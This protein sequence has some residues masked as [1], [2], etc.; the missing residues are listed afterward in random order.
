MKAVMK[1][2][3]IFPLGVIKES[4]GI[5]VAACL[6]PEKECGIVLFRKG[7]DVKE[8]CRVPFA[9]HMGAV[10]YGK[11][12]G[13]NADQV[14]YCF[15]EDDRLVSDPYMRKAAGKHRY[16]EMPEEFCL[17]RIYEDDYNWEDDQNPC[18]PWNDAICYQLHV[19]GFTKH[20][21]SKVVHKGTFAGVIEKIPYLQQLGVTT[22]EFLP[23]YDFEE[24]QPEENVVGVGA[25]G[26]MEDL[27]L[28]EEQQP[29]INYWGFKEGFYLLPKTSYSSN[30]DSCQEMKDLVKRL[31]QAGMEIILQFFFPKDYRMEQIKEVLTW[32]KQEYHVDGF[33]VK[34]ENIQIEQLATDP[35]FQDTKLIYEGFDTARIYPGKQL[36]VYKNLAYY[37]E[38]YLYELRRFLKGDDNMIRN[39]Q[40][41]FY[42]S[43]PY[44]G[45]LHSLSNYNTFTMLDMVS[46][47]RKHNEDNGEKN[48]D[49]SDNNCSWNCGEEG[50]SRKRT[51]VALRQ[52]Q[53][54]NAFL[55]LF[56]MQG[57]P[58][59][60]AGDEFG[61]TQ[62]G[63]NNP[64]CQDNS[65]NWINWKYK[66]KN[67]ELL[68]FVKTLISFRKE[69][70]IFHREEGLHMM[71]TL[72]CGCPD[73]SF[74]SEEAWRN[75]QLPYEH[76]FGAML[77]G[78]YAQ[79]ADGEWDDSFY[80]AINM[81]WQKHVFALPNLPKGMEWV[82]CMETGEDKALVAD[83]SRKAVLESR[84]I[85]I[86]KSRPIKG[87]KSDSCGKAG[88]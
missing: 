70:P 51:I 81:H 28:G 82:L 6:K 61:R 45:I 16:G 87:K 64:W 50:A 59:I 19:R 14:T 53:L 30:P 33:H 55:L 77:C 15:Y 26:S 11:L 84:S 4:D 47:D 60:M 34:G 43:S 22:L 5:H 27:V 49:G 23:V 24:V 71:D 80:L 75:R 73:L 68:Q 36:P 76:H 21:S 88:R 10:Y 52:K 9:C 2:D 46:Y 29:R 12:T 85:R 63:N 40:K 18:I 83:D 25:N 48:R 41:A 54:K 65:I 78:Q 3:R 35:V 44:Y 7:K 56:L 66:E 17:A 32:W 62:G 69:H 42:A 72:S 8:L 31:H 1:K 57:T 58:M 37:D 20:V 74:H 67:E 86:Y 79:K 39:M 38:Q 13:V